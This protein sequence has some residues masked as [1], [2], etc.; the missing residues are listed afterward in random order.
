MTNFHYKHYMLVLLTVIGVFNYLDR[1]VLGLAMESIKQ[2]FELSDGQLGLMSGFA[3]A[4]FYAVA[5]I[6]IARWADRGN[7]NH[8]ITLTTALWSVMIAVSGLVGNFYQLLLVRVGVAVGEAGC[9]PPAQSLI[10]DYFDRAERPRAMSIY[11]MSS[12][13]STLVAFIGG[14]WL[15]GQVGWRVTFMIIGV[16]GVLLALLAKFTLREPR[17]AKGVSANSV[18]A[19]EVEAEP[20]V[21][22]ASLQHVVKTLWQGRAFRYLV[23]AFCIGYFFTTGIMVWIPA[24]FI[25]THGMDVSELGVWLGL[26][27]GVGGTVFTYLGGFLATRYAAKKER[28]QMR[29]VAIIFVLCFVL[30]ALC[31]VSSSKFMALVFIS[32]VLGG[33]IQLQ[34]AP[35]YAAIQSLVEEKMRAIALALLLMFGNLIGLGLGPVA[36]GVLS[37]FLEPRFGQESLR[38]ALL[39]FSPGYLWCAYYYW[40]AGNTIEEEIR[41]LEENSESAKDEVGAQKNTATYQAATS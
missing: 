20:E 11:W 28:L 9:V 14:G 37:D 35:V 27:V 2:E 23:I 21:K 8:V 15:L 29:G 39:L 34:F 5:G 6:P 7:R 36:V 26:V 41:I 38:Y 32:I 30:F 3:F 4:L 10:S 22:P 40:K 17:L 33:V 24:F 1:N 31:Y 19:V 13:L 12:S 25:R 18:A 16:T